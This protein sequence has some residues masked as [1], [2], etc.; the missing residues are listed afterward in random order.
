MEQEISVKNAKWNTENEIQVN[1]LWRWHMTKTTTVKRIGFLLAK[2]LASCLTFFLSFILVVLFEIYKTHFWL[3]LMFTS[4]NPHFK[5][6]N[7]RKTK[8]KW[9]KFAVHNLVTMSALHSVWNDLLTRGKKPQV[10]TI[11]ADFM[12]KTRDSRAKEAHTLNCGMLKR[13]EEKTRS[14]HRLPKTINVK[15][16]HT[17]LFGN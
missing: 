7:Q 12:C 9:N 4:K 3:A 10:T 14:A 17:L 5:R 15:G 2:R 11:D 6:H 8:K 13:D 16:C 1:E